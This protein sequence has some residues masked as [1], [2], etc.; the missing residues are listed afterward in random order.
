MD[1]SSQSQQIYLYQLF[2]LSFISL[3]S[4]LSTALG[5]TILYDNN[6]IV[7]TIAN[8]ASNSFEAIFKCYELNFLSNTVNQMIL[9]SMLQMRKPGLREM[10][11]YLSMSQSL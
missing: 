9:L 1:Y 7:I 11:S 5:I 10:D 2:P 6:N 4:S 8:S 3:G